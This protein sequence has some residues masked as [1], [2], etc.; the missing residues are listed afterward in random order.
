MSEL[1]VVTDAA[2]Q[3]AA[4]VLAD[5]EGDSHTFR[6]VARDVLDAALP[7]LSWAAGSAAGDLLREKDERIAEL[8]QLAAEIL[9]TFTRTEGGHR[10]RVGQVQI[11]KWHARLNPAEPW[12]PGGGP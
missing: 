7:H 10:A 9:A 1:A 3:A 12:N 4:L 5:V 11:Q 8:K 2:I 6:D